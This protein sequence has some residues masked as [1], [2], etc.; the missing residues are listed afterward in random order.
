MRH[1]SKDEVKAALD[2]P[3]FYRSELRTL[4]APKENGEA[5]GL[6]PFHDDTVPSCSVNLVSGVFFCHACG[7]GGD[8]FSFTR[9]RYDLDFP[10]ALDKLARL[11][12]LGD[13]GRTGR[14]GPDNRNGQGKRSG[15]DGR[16]PRPAGAG[17]ANGAERS[18]VAGAT[19]GAAAGDV[20]PNAARPN[21]ARPN[22]AREITAR[23]AS[24]KDRRAGRERADGPPHGPQPGARHASQPGP[25]PG[26]EQNRRPE[27]RPETRRGLPEAPV[28]WSRPTRVYAYYSATGRHAFDVLRWEKPGHR[29]AV[30][31]SLGFDKR[32]RRIPHNRGAAPVPY[33][34]VSFD[35]RPGV[36]DA[37]RVLLV[38][39]E[40]K[41][42]ALIALGICASCNPGGAGRWRP[43]FA[44]HFTGREVVI[45]P[46]NDAPGR[47][48][49]EETARHLRGAAASVKL[50][51]LPGLPPKG[52]IIDWLRL[53]GNGRERLLALAEEA[54]LWVPAPER[55]SGAAPEAGAG[56][57]DGVS[58]G[59]EPEF[60]PHSAGP[61]A[62]D[63]P[64][65]AGQASSAPSRDAAPVPAPAS[66]PDAESGS[67][68]MPAPGGRSDAAAQAGPP[69][70]SGPASLPGGRSSPASGSASAS[71]LA[72]DWRRCTGERFMAE[73][74]AP[75]DFFWE[76]VFMRGD[77]G[78]IV[79]AP[80]SGKGHLAV[81]LLTFTGAGLPVFDE[82]RPRRPERGLYISAE[83]R[84]QTIQY[85]FRDACL[86]LP[87]GARAAA[88]ANFV[89]IPVRGRVDLCRHDRHTGLSL[90][91]HHAA[92]RALI[93][94]IRPGVVVLDT[95]SR[96]LGI[97]ENDN[98]AMTAACGMLEEL[99]RETG[100]NLL[101]IHHSNKFSGDL[102]DN[103]S[104][105]TAAL[106]QTALRGASALSGAFRLLINCAS[107]G[108]K[109][110]ASLL[111]G[112]AR[113]EQPGRYMAVRL[114][115]NNYGPLGERLF[116]RRGAH[117]FLTR[118]R[119][120]DLEAGLEIDARLLT[121]EVA[122]REQSGQSRLSL[123]R[124][125]REAFPG[126]GDSRSRK[127]ADAA[128]Q[129][130]LLQA[131][132]KGVGKGK[133]LALARPDPEAPPLFPAR[134]GH[135][136]APGADWGTAPGAA[137]VPDTARAAPVPPVPPVPN[138]P[139]VPNVL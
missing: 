58:G 40:N 111:G 67:A 114:G 23:D 24:G 119:P 118:V 97:D 127:A 26:P 122:R 123:T 65:P 108:P 117:G 82:W 92:L 101:L 135:A 130:G 37:A 5:V 72:V 85:R 6:C 1:I 102:P 2:V 11:A 31:Q 46:D 4:S 66:G 93:A 76:N 8:I 106:N 38:E 99:G 78:A 80:G 74:P 64:C 29:K 44:P 18:S 79:G 129:L 83:D 95:L 89:G 63:S 10:G 69:F 121:A 68:P 77:L 91:A 103:E 41:A 13:E 39:G 20:R 55:P 134:D 132:D 17:R 57:A 12:G 75:L 14:N 21:A 137:P 125:G 71:P 90:T 113:G 126:W 70:D 19:R 42:E 84:L 56:R 43:E 139:S 128:I 136:A 124:G 35:G 104:A 87:P 133:V 60:R 138:V 59:R 49:A 109:L 15:P 32:G 115:K 53:P 116:F 52:D 110:A 98:A 73:T 120:A 86:A 112:E 7:A 54:P 131:L 88:A 107:L 61:G 33:N 30:R 48:H 36:L 9:R 25:E 16:S 45:L 3:A 62:P 34:L 50:L 96:F 22:A 94:D 81:R 28:D 51:E 47:R 105:L 27:A 100:C